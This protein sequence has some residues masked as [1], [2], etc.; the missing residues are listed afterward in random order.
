MPDD[1]LVQELT[2]VALRLISASIDG[3][4]EGEDVARAIG[5]DP[6]DPNAELHH[7]FREIQRQGRLSVRAWEGGMGLPADIRLPPGR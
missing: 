6:E 3:I 1:A 7:A 5:R 4:V 2:D